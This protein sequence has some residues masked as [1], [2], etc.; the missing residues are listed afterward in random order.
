MA[1]SV[2][3]E[4]SGRRAAVTISLGLL[5]SLFAV[6][7]RAQGNRILTFKNNCSQTVWIGAVGGFTQNCGF[8]NSC[9]A[10]QACLTTRNPPGCF[11]VLPTPSSGTFALPAGATTTVTLSAPPQG[12]TKW[13]G[14]IYGSTGCDSAGKNCQTGVCVGGSCPP[15]TGPVG[16]TTLAEFTLIT[17]ASDTYDIA[18]IH[19]VNVPMAM[20]PTAGQNI[21]PAPPGSTAAYWCG[22]PGSPTPSNPALVGCSWTFNPTVNGN[23]YSTLLRMVA[24]GGPLCTRD[25]DCAVPRVCGLSMVVG[26]TTVKQTCGRHIGWWSANEVC[27]FTNSAF[28]AP[29]NC[30]ATVSGQG[31]NA[32]LY[33]C[34]GP[35]ASTCY[36][37][38]ATATCCGCPKWIINGTTLPSPLKCGPHNTTTNPA[39]NSI[40]EPWARFLKAACPT[41]YSFAYDDSTSTFVCQTAGTSSTTPNAL[42][43][44]ITYCPGGRTGL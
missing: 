23:N 27:I 5:I 6:A 18:A 41:A 17:N 32:N 24:P 20:A 42:N 16:P 11:W 14:N 25:S 40:S 30:R 12:T 31:T 28:G 9:P 1:T 35:N 22:H 39:W 8:N 44:T 37:D 21:P 10:G 43:Y 38:L 13:S 2:L 33:G 36:N 7:A 34:D 26:T 29:F 15:G 3:W 19:G 4:R